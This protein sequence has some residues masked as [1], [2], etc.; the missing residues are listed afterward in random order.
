[1]TELFLKI[2]IRS[3]KK[4]GRVIISTPS[5]KGGSD[6]HHDHDESFIDEHV[7]DGYGIDEIDNKLKDAGFNKV[8]AKYTYGRPG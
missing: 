2:S 7:R 3:L 4:G 8:V 1:M 6:V 5:D